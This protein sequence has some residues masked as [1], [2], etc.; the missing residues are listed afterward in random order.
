MF[1]KRSRQHMAALAAL[2][3]GGVAIHASQQPAAPR[4]PVTTLHASVAFIVNTGNALGEVPIEEL[5]RILL[6]EITRWPDGRKITIAM[7]GQ[8]EPERDAVLRLVCRMSDQDY[9]RYLLHASYRGELQGG[10]PKLLDTPNGV[11]RFVFNVPGAI[12][13]VRGDDVDDTVKV[14]R[15]GGPVPA[16]PAFGL[17]LRAR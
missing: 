4:A 3:A 7:R 12:G 13:Y 2:V 10:G 15:I 14:I 9:T 8:G 1:S 17:T 11:R 5:R 6:G 16:Q